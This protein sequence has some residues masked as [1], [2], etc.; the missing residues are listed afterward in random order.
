MQDVPGSHSTRE[1]RAKRAEF[2]GCAIA[3]VFGL[4][5]CEGEIQRGHIIPV[6]RPDLNPTDNIENIIPICR[7]HNGRSGQWNQTL[8][9][10]LGAGSEKQ[11]RGS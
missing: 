1:W 8:D 7:G 3:E 10:W 4:D 6:S 2:D 5:D 9:E 11:V